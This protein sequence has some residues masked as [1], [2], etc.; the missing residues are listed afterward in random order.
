MK[1]SEIATDTAPIYIHIRDAD[2]FRIMQFSYLGNSAEVDKP[3][4]SYPSNF[5]IYQR[6]KNILL[7]DKVNCSCKQSCFNFFTLYLVIT[8]GEKEQRIFCGRITDKSTR[9]IAYK[10][11][12]PRKYLKDSIE[13]AIRQEVYAD[14]RDSKTKLTPKEID[15]LVRTRLSMSFPNADKFD[16]LIKRSFSSIK[17]DLGFPATDPVEHAYKVTDAVIT[18]STSEP[19]KEYLERLQTRKTIFPHELPIIEQELNSKCSDINEATLVFKKFKETKSR[20]HLAA[21]SITS[22]KDQTC[23]SIVNTHRQYIRMESWKLLALIER[24]GEALR[25]TELIKPKMGEPP[26]VFIFNENKEGLVVGKFDMKMSII[27]VV[28]MDKGGTKVHDRATFIVDS[29]YTLCIYATLKRLKEDSERFKL[30]REKAQ[31]LL[32]LKDPF[33]FVYQPLKS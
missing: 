12:K 21:Y 1:Y 3:V 30:L 13:S 15:K 9:N 22:E 7:T 4:A 20:E 16:E 17:D 29:T 5:E 28:C 24:S 33:N 10:I 18:V 14:T 31:T 19:C 27:E 25:L 2:F 6:W 8:A 11:E 23:I 32:S 26:P